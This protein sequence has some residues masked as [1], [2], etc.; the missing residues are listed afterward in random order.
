MS[1]K[2]L[3]SLAAL[4]C[5]ALCLQ[6]QTFQEGFFLRDYKLAYQYNPALAA[7]S[8]NFLSVAQWRSQSLNN[9][10]ASAYMYPTEDG[11]VLGL[12][13][14]I[15]ADVFLGNLPAQDRSRSEFNFGLFSYGFRT[16]NAFH[17]LELN[18]R[19]LYSMTVPKELFEFL[20]LGAGDSTFKM[21]GFNIGGGIFAEAVYGYSRRLNSWLSLGVR[22]KLL[23]PLFGA[24]YDIDRL[25]V[26]ATEDKVEVWHHGDLYLTNLTT[27]LKPNEQ[28]YIDLLYTS[29]HGK[30]GVRP[31]GV[32][33]AAD[34]GLVATP[35][36][37][38]TLSASVQD[39]G[40]MFWYYGNRMTAAGPTTFEGMDFGSLD[41][42]KS[43][44]FSEKLT[45]VG[46][47]FLQTLKPMPANNKWLF[48]LRSFQANLGLKYEMPFYRRLAV[49]ATAL[50]QGCSTVPYWETRLAIEANPW[51]WLDVTATFGTGAF[52]PVFGVAG[53]VKVYKFR[54]TAGLQDGFGGTVRYTSTPLKANFRS[55]TI[56]LT[57]DL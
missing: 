20:K 56:G 5:V 33:L 39:L 34:L 13:S 42:I 49:G 43:G 35:V 32:G 46:D 27:Q 37:G 3:L 24:Q 28:G 48:F 36:D 7:D 10:G 25:D 47:T 57:Y 40:C 51:N 17:T 52:G 21:G 54:L 41:N 9:V 15:P 12:N 8:E 45:A 1:K 23:L 44:S 26:T 31:S 53:A 22:A 50:Y 14:A 18:V 38:L 4:L 30:L 29:P 19:G 2:T 55:F 16:T 6:A 11:L